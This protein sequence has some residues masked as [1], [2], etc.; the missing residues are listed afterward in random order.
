M[1]HAK[2]YAA[3]KLLAEMRTGPVRARSFESGLMGRCPRCATDEACRIETVDIGG[4]DFDPREGATCY[5]RPFRDEETAVAYLYDR[6]YT[7]G[8]A[9]VSYW[10][11]GKQRFVHRRLAYS[12]EYPRT[13]WMQICDELATYLQD[14][15]MYKDLV[16]KYLRDIL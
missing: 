8:G 13:G 5:N 12:K 14:N 1:N 3:E 6:Y 2:Y 15:P 7:T 4:G 16:H 11:D 10:A 9:L